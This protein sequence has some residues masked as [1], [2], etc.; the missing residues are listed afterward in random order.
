MPAV[1]TMIAQSDSS[2]IV[3]LSD[4]PLAW[5]NM[6]DAPREIYLSELI[7][8]L[9]YALDLTE[10]LP[11]GHCLRA[12]WLG[13][14]IGYRLD[15]TERELSDLYYT[16]LLK[17]AGCSSNAARL[18]EL[19]ANDEREIKRNY[20]TLDTQSFT[21]V[22]RFVL[23]NLAPE[24]SLREKLGRFINLAMNG[25]KLQTELVQGRCER[26]SEIAR[27][28]GFS[29]VVAEGIACLAEYWNGKGRPSGLAGTAI[30]LVSRI[31]LIAQVAE[32]FYSAGG[33]GEAIRQLRVRSG[34]WFD[35]V[36]VQTAVELSAEPNFFGALDSADLEIRVRSLEPSIHACLVND[37]QM[38]EIAAAFARVIDS[39]SPFTF[40][41]SSR[42]ARYTVAISAAMG[43][44]R[45]QRQWLRRTALLH[46]I[47]KLGVSNAILDKPGKLT[48]SEWLKVKEHPTFS[49]EILKRIP[50]FAELAVVA[51]SHHERLDGKGYPRGIGGSDIPMEAR[52][53][54]TADIFDAITAERPYRK[55]VP[56]HD[57]LN[58]MDKDAGTA[59]DPECL[60]ALKD[61]IRRG[62]DCSSGI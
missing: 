55:A 32:V 60:A 42:V 50:I 33:A 58:I 4:A 35:P 29:E 53:L 5:M 45:Q 1:E 18:F 51:G 43:F 26:G 31:A 9:S 54:T 38:D 37:T 25:E 34:V 10:G 30:P 36:L 52:I 21:R 41:H 22:A 46:D 19:Y 56:V 23:A 3:R 20:A 27:Q 28:M 24:A 7:G 59:I 44:S 49:E 15:L 13:M 57:T 12:C 17:D 2:T 40:G 47:G 39:K 8:A 61:V 62:L 6:S 11:P 14:K 48:D 16:I